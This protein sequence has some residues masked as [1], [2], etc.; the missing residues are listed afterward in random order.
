MKDFFC[1]IK[2]TIT[3]LSKNR[4][5][6]VNSISRLTEAIR[7][8]HSLTKTNKIDTIFEHIH[9]MGPVV[10]VGGKKYDT[11]T[12]VIAFEYFSISRSL[13]NR[14]REDYE[15]PSISLL[16]RITSKLDSS[17]DDKDYLNSL[18]SHLDEMQK[19]CPV[20]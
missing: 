4:L 19:H 9:A 16:T 13:Y 14:L 18:F 20:F 8:L 1:G 2:H 15:L 17:L 6:C 11:N 12:F 10:M 5:T 7:Y 3:S